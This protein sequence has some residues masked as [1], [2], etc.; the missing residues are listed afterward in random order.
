[1]WLISNYCIRLSYIRSEELCRSRR[2][3]S[4]EIHPTSIDVKFSSLF[5]C[6]L[7][8]PGYKEM[9]CLVDILQIVIRRVVSF[10]VLAMSVLGDS[11][12]ISSSQNV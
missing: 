11:S 12:V 5:A 4:P 10:S 1:M 2:A 3:L 9:F 8:N 7:E 6:S